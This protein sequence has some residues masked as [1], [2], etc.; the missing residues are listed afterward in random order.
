MFCYAEIFD[1]KLQ[2]KKSLMG[3]INELLNVQSVW[4]FF[5]LQGTILPS[6]FEVNTANL[7]IGRTQPMQAHAQTCESIPSQK[8]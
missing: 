8:N 1:G 4:L 6:K 3:G 7:A 2:K 5:R